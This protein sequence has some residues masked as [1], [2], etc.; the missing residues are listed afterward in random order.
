MIVVDRPA[1]TDPDTL[2]AE[3]DVLGLGP[4]RLE[5]HD[6]ILAFVFDKELSDEEEA[7]LVAVVAAHD[8]SE[9]IAKRREEA[10]KIAAI[11]AAN[12]ALVE[13]AKIKRLA[14][15]ALSQA[16]LAALVDAVLFPG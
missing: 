2:H 8:G 16:E 1:H 6:D 10:E 5:W 7:Q 4:Y 12:K 14:G 13:S 3:V 9:A 11:Q 15:Q